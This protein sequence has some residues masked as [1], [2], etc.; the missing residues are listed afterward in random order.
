MR[1]SRNPWGF[2]PIPPEQFHFAL[3]IPEL[4]VIQTPFNV[5]DRRLL[6]S[7]LLDRALDSGR[8]I[9]LRSIYLQGLLLM[10]A[11]KLSSHMSFAADDVRR[12]EALCF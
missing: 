11:D 3:T 6:E 2:P 9:V 7:G 10:D 5:L 8:V 12:W 1:V 4:R